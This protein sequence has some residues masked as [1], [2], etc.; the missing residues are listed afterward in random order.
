MNRNA[1]AAAGLLL[2]LGCASPALPP[3]LLAPQLSS[4]PL[5]RPEQVFL[6]SSRGDGNLATR[7][8][9]PVHYTVQN[10][11]TAD[12]DSLFRLDQRVTFANGKVESR[13]WQI[14][15]LDSHHYSAKLTDATGDV[16][17][18]TTGNLFHLRYLLRH[19]G[20]HM[21]QWLYLQPDGTVLNIGKVKVLGFLLAQLSETITPGK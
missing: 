16:S 3:P 7:G 19:P 11:G 2:F 9:A 4:A 17:A 6:G 21:E 1:A 15:R 8:K 5:F 18:E 14:H 12:S 13:T 20:V 10:L